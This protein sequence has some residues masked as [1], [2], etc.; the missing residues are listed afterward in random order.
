MSFGGQD[1]EANLYVSIVHFTVLQTIIVRMK[2]QKSE[3]NIKDI[4]TLKLKSP[5]ESK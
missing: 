1:A 2:F 4:Y 5:A 3:K